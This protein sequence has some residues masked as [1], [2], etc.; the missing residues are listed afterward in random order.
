MYYLL[1][2]H[3]RNGME[4]LHVTKLSTNF[5]VLERMQLLFVLTGLPIRWY[6]DWAATHSNHDRKT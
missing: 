3:L 2:V 1:S 6:A 5:H 4:N